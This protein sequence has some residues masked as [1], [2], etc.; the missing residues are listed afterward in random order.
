VDAESCSLAGWRALVVQRDRRTY[1]PSLPFPRRFKELHASEYSD[2]VALLP[3]D[4]LNEA[5]AGGG[6]GGRGAPLD[7][8]TT[9]LLSGNPL[10]LFAFSLL[11]WVQFPQ[12]SY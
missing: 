1:H 3:E 6:G 8:A 12:P 9:E 2:A 5:A 11:P 10:Y 7:A 4:A